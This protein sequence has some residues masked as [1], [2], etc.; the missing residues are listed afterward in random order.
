MESPVVDTKD[1]LRAHIDR[2]LA[3]M[4]SQQAA[5]S[6]SRSVLY[7]D[8]NYRYYATDE[9]TSET[10]VAALRAAHYEE[11]PPGDPVQIVSVH[12]SRGIRR[13]RQPIAIDKLL[14]ER[15]A[16]KFEASRGKPLANLMPY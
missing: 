2:A 15:E 4:E 14:R 8:P 10:V 16:A 5:E 11:C 12:G 7:G 9:S 13:W 1:E 3:A 6:E